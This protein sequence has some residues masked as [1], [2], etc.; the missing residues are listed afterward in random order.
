MGLLK[1]RLLSDI[2]VCQSTAKGQILSKLFYQ[3]PSTTW[4]RGWGHHRVSAPIFCG[5][6][7]LHPG[8]VTLP[9]TGIWRKLA[10]PPV[11]F[12]SIYCCLDPAEWDREKQVRRGRCSKN[13]Q[14]YSYA[15]LQP[16]EHPRP[17]WGREP[18]PGWVSQIYSRGQGC[19]TD[20]QGHICKHC[21]VLSAQV[22]STSMGLQ[23]P[24]PQE[25]WWKCTP[26]GPEKTQAV[27]TPRTSAP[28]IHEEGKTHFVAH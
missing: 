7:E 13:S 11:I 24:N 22:P 20:T 3:N 6:L 1:L 27:L 26:E 25:L 2:S 8:W 16:P 10:S 15:L 5:P 17:G 4:R 19:F 12:Y 28:V 14:I 9:E 21:G 18:P 23:Q